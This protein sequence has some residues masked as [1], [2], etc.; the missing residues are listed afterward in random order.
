MCVCVFFIKKTRSE[1]TLLTQERK[2]N[3][4]KQNRDKKKKNKQRVSGE[5]L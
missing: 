3:K 2:Y 1:V 4:N 5:L